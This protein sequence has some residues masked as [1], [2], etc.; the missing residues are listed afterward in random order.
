MAGA[1]PAFLAQGLVSRAG[2]AG[3]RTGGLAAAT[4]KAGIEPFTKANSTSV[5]VRRVHL[6]CRHMP[7]AMQVTASM[8]CTL[9]KERAQ[10]FQQLRS[11]LVPQET[12]ETRLVWA[13]EQKRRGLQ[14]AH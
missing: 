8:K 9:L 3:G 12:V 2:R 14:Q 4:E 1:P 5:H 11:Y 13:L 6:M 10:M 7:G